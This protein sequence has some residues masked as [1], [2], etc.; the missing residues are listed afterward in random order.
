MKIKVVSLDPGRAEALAQHVRT[1]GAGLDVSISAVGPGGLPTIINGSRPGLIVYDGVDDEGLEH[2]GRLTQLHPDVD[3]IV[4]S[5]VQSPAFL[6]KAMKAG[7]REVLP[8]QVSGP[9]IQAA[10]QRLV[11]KRPQ[12]VPVKHGQVYAFMSCKGGNGASFLAANLAH[13]LAHRAEHTVALLDFDLQF[14]DCLL[15]LADQRAQSTVADVA[16]ELSRLDASLLQAAMVQITP[17][18]FVLSA[19]HDLTQSLEVKAHHVEAIVKQAVQMYDYVVVD[20]SRSIDSVTLKV[21]D[22]ADRILPVVQLTLPNLRDAKRLRDLFRSLEYPAHKVKWVI[23]RHHKAS[24][25]TLDAFDQALGTKDA[26]VIPN[27]HVSVSESVNRGI[28]IEQTGKS[29]PV[30]KALQN[31]AQVLSPYE[32][33]RKDNWLSSIFGGGTS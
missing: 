14:G 28:A 23:N 15:M 2:I 8:Q 26:I 25:I 19:P 10:V 20:A 12:A 11:R 18:L 22:L 31:M 5:D 21:L 27:H 17:S 30:V 9:E 3:T 24:E 7:V 16:L 13:V 1:S 29:N 33:P 6:L 32:A 4:V